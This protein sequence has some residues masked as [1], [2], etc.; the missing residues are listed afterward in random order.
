MASLP[1]LKIALTLDRPSFRLQVDLALPRSGVTVFFGASGSGKTTLLRCVAGL[2]RAIGQVALGD[3]IWQ[4]SQRRLWVPTWQRDLGYVFQE[5]SLFEHMTVEQNLMFGVQRVKK[6]GSAQALAKA[7][8]LLGIGHLRARAVTSLSGGERQRV[9]IARALA[10]EPQVLLLD[11]PLAS[12]D[13]ARKREIMP[14]LQ[15]MRT[16]LQIPVLYV[17]H[18]VDE[19][20]CLADHVVVLDQGSVQ[21]HGALAEVLANT[22]L[23]NLMGEEAGVTVDGAV[24][25]LD[26]VFHLAEVQTDAG[27]L[28]VRDQG[29]QQHQPVRL[30]LLARDISLSAEP[31]NNST[32][33]N[34]LQ[35]VI[36]TLAPDQHPAQC[37]VKIRCNDC[38]LLA[39]VTYRA[40]DRLKLGLG[41]S[42]WCLVKTAAVMT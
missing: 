5:A 41:A 22:A 11:E 14:W 4:D 33:Q 36:E 35:G 3:M 37:L 25:S 18:S 29:L 17:T 40:L 10:T 2:E 31:V 23:A 9:A 20:M 13:I 39:R 26:P 16:Q 19:M 6:R 12:L 8:E 1:T 7:I 34:Q 32:I 28:W 15:S 27:K 30:R 42:V 21:T 38:L 24:L